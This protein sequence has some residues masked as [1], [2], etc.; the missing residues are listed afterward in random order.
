MLILT[1]KTVLVRS[2]SHLVVLLRQVIH[3]Y[4]RSASAA[5]YTG[6]F[7]SNVYRRFYSVT[8]YVLHVLRT[9]Y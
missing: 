7:L 8:F 6:N 2:S 9:S 3:Y 1:V 5:E 4:I